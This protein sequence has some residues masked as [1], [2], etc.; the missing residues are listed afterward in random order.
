[1]KPRTLIV[2]AVLVALLGAFIYFVE[3]DLP[4]TE[5]RAERAR[6]LLP[7]LEPSEVTGVEIAWE[8]QRVVLERRQGAQASGGGDGEEGAPEPELEEDVEPEEAWYLVE[9]LE[10]RA[11]PGR[12]DGL[13]AALA[14]LETKRT[15]EGGTEG[16]SDG[17]GGLD[18]EELGLEPAR[19]TAILS[20]EGGEPRELR[21]GRELPASEDRLAAVGQPGEPAGER[22]VHVVADTVWV[23]LTREPGQWRD[24]RILAVE[25]DDVRRVRVTAPERQEAVVLVRQGRGYR[26][27][28]PVR[29][30][31]GRRQARALFDAL[32][33]LRAQRFVDDP[34]EGALDPLQAILEITLEGR[35]PMTLEVGGMAEQGPQRYYGR[36]EGRTFVFQSDAVAMAAERPVGD[37]RSRAWTD[38][39]V[40]EVEGLSVEDAEGTLEVRRQEGRWMREDPAAGP[41][42][43]PYT[44]VSELLYAAVDAEAEELLSPAE[45]RGE[46]FELEEPIVTLELRTAP[47]A[48]GDEDGREDGADGDADGGA[49]AEEAEAAPTQTQTLTLYPPVEG[50]VP[51]RTSDREAVLVFP[52]DHLTTVRE[53]IE[54]VREAEP[55]EEAAAEEA[56]A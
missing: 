26:L 40:F 10:S 17:S 36:A 28:E 33:D 18:L 29:D 32:A 24:P 43:L 52:Q 23:D 50:R 25:P 20:T 11:D 12:V 19:L 35:S 14:G 22:P 6:K 39:D 2:L 53:A 41:E 3:R 47:A 16:E 13:L 15:L 56:G 21:L 5:E 37:W 30:R 44:P 55:V 48:D 8:D 51:A 9:P 38:L 42:E 31:A 45:A 27:E 1:M 4:G 54:A 7:E 49:G 46:G 34:P